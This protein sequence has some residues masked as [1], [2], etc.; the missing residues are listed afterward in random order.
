MYMKSE[1]KWVKI[2]Q[3]QIEAKDEQEIFLKYVDFYQGDK[4]KALLAY[5]YGLHLDPYWEG[6]NKFYKIGV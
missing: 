6:Y 1:D 4:L 3:N 2:T 5:S